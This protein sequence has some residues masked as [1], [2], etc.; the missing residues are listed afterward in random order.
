MRREGERFWR[1]SKGERRKSKSKNAALFLFKIFPF[2]KCLNKKE[3][4]P[5]FCFL[6]FAFRL[7]PFDFFP[8]RFSNPG[9]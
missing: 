1:K 4:T 9:K 2:H 6:P 5:H 8:M 3:K 7:S